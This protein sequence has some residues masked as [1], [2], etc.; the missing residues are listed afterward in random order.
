[1]TEC[2][3]GVQKCPQGDESLNHIMRFYPMFGSTFAKIVWRRG[4]GGLQ[5]GGPLASSSTFTTGPFLQQSASSQPQALL[6]GEGPASVI[7]MLILD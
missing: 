1:M 4:I 5:K 7:R 3:L 2:L 6:P